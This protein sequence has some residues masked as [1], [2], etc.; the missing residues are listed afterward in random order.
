[1][2][3][4][5]KV[6]QISELPLGSKKKVVWKDKV[7]LLTNINN[8]YF[9]VDNTCPHMGGSLVDGNL[10]GNHIVCPRHGSIFDVTTGKV[11]QSGKLLF[12]KVKVHDLQSY[13]VKIEGPDLLIGI[14]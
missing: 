1:M 8:T 3:N 6:A 4:Y 14:E 5:V 9:A 2:M 12:I 13:P 7:I 11:V 10:D